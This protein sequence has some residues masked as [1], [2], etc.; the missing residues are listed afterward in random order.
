MDLN[1]EIDALT[2]FLE[3][4]LESAD[5]YALVLNRGVSLANGNLCDVFRKSELK[6]MRSHK[7]TA[8]LVLQTADRNMKASRT[9][10]AYSV[11]IQRSETSGELVEHHDFFLEAQQRTQEQDRSSFLTVAREQ[12]EAQSR[13]LLEACR[14]LAMKDQASYDRLVAE[15]EG[16]RRQLAEALA[17]EAANIAKYREMASLEQERADAMASRAFRDKMLADLIHTGADYILPT[18]MSGAMGGSDP[19]TGTVLRHLQTLKRGN[20]TQL[21]AFMT[22]LDPMVLAGLGAVISGD[23]SAQYV[24]IAVARAMR[25]VPPSLAKDIILALGPPRQD[26]EGKVTPNE[27]QNAFYEL[28]SLREHTWSARGE[29]MIEALKSGAGGDIL[30]ALMSE[31]EKKKDDPPKDPPKDP[32]P[33]LQ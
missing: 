1:E 10:S 16:T 9:S 24:H 8:A 19:A 18:L 2:S 33:S 13:T 17:R 29:K 26:A 21:D 31:T 23:V 6:S 4:K 25:N 27:L 14:S 3:R 30:K 7:E 32:P 22:R 12:N 28:W 5:F 20:V 11:W 15:L